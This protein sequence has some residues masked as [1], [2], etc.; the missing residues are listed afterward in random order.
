MNRVFFKLVLA[1]IISVVLCVEVF[2]AEYKVA[3]IIAQKNFRDEEF[4]IPKSMFEEFGCKVDVYSSKR[5]I[6]RGMLG[7][8]VEVKKTIKDLSP[9]EYDAIVLVGGMGANEYWND[10]TL[11]K[12]LR[13]AVKEGKIVGAI[14]IAPV[15]LANAGVLEGKKA[16]VWESCKRMLE[17]KGAVCTGTEVEIDGNVVTANGPKAARLFGYKILELLIEGSG[18]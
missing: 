18:S 5:G 9:Q 4:T 13:E 8:T 12:I 17:G 3:V 11:H 6:A 14:C 2:G 10:A 15:T 16:T 7:Y 1:C